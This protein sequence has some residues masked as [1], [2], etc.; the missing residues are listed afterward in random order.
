MIPNFNRTKIIATVGPS[1]NTYEMLLE[2]VRTGVNMFRF[3]FSHGTH[4]QHKKVFEHIHKINRA[5]KLNIGILADLQGP[6]IRIGE[7]KDNHIELEKGMELN[8]TSHKSIST[9]QQLYVSYEQLPRDAQPGDKILL[10]DGKVELQVI[11][12]NGVDLLKVKV[13]HGGPLS[14]KKGVNLPDTKLSTSSITDKDKADLEFAMANGANWIAMSFVRSPDDVLELRQLIGNTKKHR[15]IAKIEKP[16]ALTCIDEIITVSDAIMIARGDLGVEVPME[17]MP[18]I[19]KDIVRRCVLASKPVVVATQIMESMMTASRPTRAE[20]NDVANDMI[21]PA[22]ASMLSGETA[23]GAHTIK[24][25]ETLMRIM[26]YIEQEGELVYNRKG[27]PDRSSKTYISDS[28]C[29]S[30]ARMSETVEA[31]AIIGMTRSGYTAFMVSSYRP[32]A[33]III[34]TDSE[35]LLNILSISWGVQAYYYD[36]FVSTDESIN[37]VIEF[38]KSKN[39]VGKGDLVINTGTMP[40][41]KQGRANFV[42]VT[43]VE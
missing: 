37:D 23:A 26:K 29:H 41:H 18:L 21:D 4:E 32:K 7:V 43:V 20:I 38:I 12:S 13:L 27:R 3:N 34:F 8:I 30:A 11:S 10:D 5:Y 28:I 16:E 24:V 31:K 1:S 9:E 14:S 17:R 2:L 39:I 40:L 6:K 25:V 22:D 36:K 19:Q 35:D 15:I 42:K 33:N